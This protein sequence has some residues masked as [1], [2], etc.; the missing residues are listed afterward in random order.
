[1]HVQYI[2]NNNDIELNR[3]GK[4]VQAR[5]VRDNV[6]LNHKYEMGEKVKNKLEMRIN[7]Q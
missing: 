5:N 6:E 7:D 1:V 3:D 2:P 4:V